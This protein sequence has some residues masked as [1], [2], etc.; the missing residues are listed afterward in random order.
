MK[1]FFQV[2]EKD[3]SSKRV[4]SNGEKEAN[5]GSGKEPLVFMSWNANSL[6]LRLKKNR[7]ELADFIQQLD[8]D[9]IAIQEVRIPAAGC[10]GGMKNQGEVKDDT[11]SSREEKQ[12]LMRAISS[13]P[14]SNY[15]V[16]WSLGEAKYGGT[17]L[18][19]KHHFQPLKL[20][21]SLDQT[22]PAL[23]HETDGR[24]I[25]AEFESFRLVNTYVPNNGWKD[26][27][28][29]F[30]RRR[31][32][33]QRMLDFVLQVSDKP[34]IWCGDLNVSHNDID[35]SHPEF[36]GNAKMAGYTPPNEE[37]CGQPGFTIGERRRFSTILSHS[38]ASKR[39][40]STYSFIHSI[41]RNRLYSKK[42]ED[43]VYV[44][45]NLQ[46]FTHKE[47]GYKEVGCQ[48]R[49]YRL[50]CFHCPQTCGSLHKE[51]GYKEVGSHAREYRLGCFHCPLCCT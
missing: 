11:S 27:E 35:V 19:L 8:P 37:D 4:K 45:S 43:L 24:V 39:N 7:T 46:L 14:F 26:D 41:K 49:E 2:V 9:V 21:F 31:K 50:G 32:W 22:S 48:A 5:V 3:T 23:K 36:F 40:W 1:R 13:P 10:K 30:K 34:L 29:G 15:H 28:N 6:L 38:S 51:S 12:I 44:H 20:T 33:D 47:S 18:F 25:V 17:A 16:W 42:A